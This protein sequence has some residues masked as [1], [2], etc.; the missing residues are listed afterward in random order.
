MSYDSSHWYDRKGFPCHTQPTKPGAKNPTRNTTIADAKKLGL[1]PS[2]SGITRMMSSPGLEN[3]KLRQVAEVCFSRPPIGDE[4]LNGYQAYVLE[5]AGQPARDAADFGTIVH[6]AIEAVL[7]GKAWSGPQMATHPSTGQ[8]MPVKAII[9]PVIDLLGAKGVA[10]RCAEQVLTNQMGYAGT[11]DLVGSRER[12]TIICDFKTKR[13]SKDKPIECP[14]TYAMQLAAY[15]MALADME[16]QSHMLIDAPCANIFISSTEPG[17]VEWYE[18]SVEELRA[19]WQA[20]QHCFG[21]WK[22]DNDYD[23]KFKRA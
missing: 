11:T 16:G 21:L 6:S 14:S 8:Q 22:W 13:T 7:A 1:L 18:H 2:V 12:M 9:Q 3:Y 15:R 10:V 4:D 20:F 23:P 17:R 19:A 5:K